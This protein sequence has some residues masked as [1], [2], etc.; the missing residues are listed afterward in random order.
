M[1]LEEFFEFYR[2]HSLD[3]NKEDF[4]P[5]ILDYPTMVKSIQNAHD[6]ESYQITFNFSEFINKKVMD[7]E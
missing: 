5:Y 1:S 7:N 6:P 2:I 3:S 4:H